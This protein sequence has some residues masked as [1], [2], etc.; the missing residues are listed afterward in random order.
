MSDSGYH[1]K[2]P[3]L[4]PE[5]EPVLKEMKGSGMKIGL[6]SNAAR[7]A[8]T[9]GRMMEF[10]FWHLAIFR[11]SY[12]LLRSRLPETAKNVSAA[13]HSLDVRPREALHVGDLF[14]ADIVGATYGMITCP[15]HGSVA[16]I[17][18]VH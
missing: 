9:Y 13:L 10:L 4:N 12:Y 8:N 16:Q 18:A 6:I 14:K 1:A 11:Y 7:S 2:Y 3:N 17:C 5:A 15:L